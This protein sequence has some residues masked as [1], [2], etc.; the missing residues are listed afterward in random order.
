MLT[1]IPRSALV[2]LGMLTIKGPLTPKEISDS[3][4]LPARTVS[5]AL[6]RLVGLKLIA[7]KP[8]FEDM[9]QSIYHVRQSELRTLL[10]EPSAFPLIHWPQ[11]LLDWSRKT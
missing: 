7:K 3:S 4:R 8:N 11:A 6:R 1:D 10:Q 5:F 2:V 9:R